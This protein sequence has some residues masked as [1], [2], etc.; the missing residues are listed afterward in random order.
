MKHS[1]KV[2]P[3][4]YEAIKDGIKQIELRLYDEKRKEIRLGDTIEILKE[5]DLKERILVKVIG[6]LH[7]ESFPMLLRDFDSS[8]VAGPTV[9]KEE[10]LRDL[11]VYYSKEKQA[12]F[13]VLGIRFTK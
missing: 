3:R 4:Y 5:P 6:L 1:M 2:Q 11:E 9:S 8:I 10:L 12:K 13:G 7:Y